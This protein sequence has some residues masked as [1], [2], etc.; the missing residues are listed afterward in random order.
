MEEAPNNDKESSHSAHT[1]GMNEWSMIGNKW[2]AENVTRKIY[3]NWN[4]I[5][6]L[7]KPW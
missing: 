2:C 7:D 5:K 6:I 3:V 4:G 1:N